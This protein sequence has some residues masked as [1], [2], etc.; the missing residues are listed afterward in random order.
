MRAVRALIS[1][2]ARRAFALCQRCLL[3]WRYWSRLGYSWHLAWHV[4]ERG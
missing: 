4:A 3:A 1:G 2:L